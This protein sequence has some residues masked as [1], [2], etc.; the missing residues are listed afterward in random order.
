MKK[1]LTKILRHPLILGPVRWFMI[2]L[3]LF[4]ILPLQVWLNQVSMFATGKLIRCPKIVEW[5]DSLF[6]DEI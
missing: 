6:A 1:L 5:V 3:M 4:V 2:V